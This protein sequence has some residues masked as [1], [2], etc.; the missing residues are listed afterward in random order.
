MEHLIRRLAEAGDHLPAEAM[1][2]AIA[3]WETAAPSLLALLEAYAEGRDRSKAAT[4]AV[5]FIL[6]LAAEARETRAFPAICRLALDPEA[7][8]AALGDGITENL[9]AILAATWDGDLDRLLGIAGAAETDQ[10]IR[11]AAIGALAMLAAQG[12]LPMERAEAALGALGTSMPESTD[13]PFGW[14]GWQQAVALLGLERLQPVVRSVFERGLIGPEFMDFVDFEKDLAAGV[15]AATPE[16][17][18]ALLDEAHMAP[19]TDAVALLSSWHGFSEAF[20]QEQA[21][22]EAEWEAAPQPAR[23][24]YRDVGRNDPCPCGSGMKF[25]KC[26]LPA[27][28]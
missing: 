14:I 9:A 3:Q 12:A 13:A 4:S 2:E 26:C 17:R 1:R 19:I 27:V 15:A 20:R 18:Q 5:F 7:M 8:E 21:A 6:F 24:P 25:K 28:A 22:R 23:N 16:A 11:N 10:F